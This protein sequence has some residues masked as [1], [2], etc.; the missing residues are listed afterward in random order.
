MLEFCKFLSEQIIFSC[1]KISNLDQESL[2][3]FSKFLEFN[4]EFISESNKL[5]ACEEILIYMTQ[6]KELQKLQFNKILPIIYHLARVLSES[7]K[8]AEINKENRENLPENEMFGTKIKQNENISEEQGDQTHYF[9][10]FQDGLG[11]ISLFFQE[12]IVKKLP[13]NMMKSKST[14]IYDQDVQQSFSVN[15]KSSHFENFAYI[16]PIFSLLR[17]ELSENLVKVIVP[18]LLRDC[19]NWTDELL[20]K[21]LLLLHEKKVNNFE[22]LNNNLFIFTDKSLGNFRNLH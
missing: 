17:L 21:N 5:V 4:Q 11:K 6:N 14:I 8:K 22:I 1:R 12:Y 9:Q 3:N 20:M 7:Q 13:E 10:D 18:Q 2:L 15:I 16:L 19:I